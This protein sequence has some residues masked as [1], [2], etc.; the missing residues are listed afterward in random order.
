MNN[1]FTT[2]IDGA[3]Q[4]PTVVASIVNWNCH[5]DTAC[6]IDNLQKL[7]Y[8]NLKIIIVDNA[9]SDESVRILSTKYPSVTLLKADENNGYAAG[10]KLAV[11]LAISEQIDLVW[12][13]N[14][15]VEFQ[16]AAVL[17]S[18]VSAYME[19]GEGI[20][21]SVNITTKEHL[22]QEN[23]YAVGPKGLPSEEK[24]LHSQLPLETQI[25][26]SSP[27]PV[28]YAIGSSYM[29][30]TSV[31]KR[32]GFM[33]ERF[34]MY[35]EE[36]EYCYRLARQNVRT[37]LVPDSVVVH[38][39]KKTTKG[40]AI[41]TQIRH[42]YLRRNTLILKRKYEGWW[43][44]LREVLTRKTFKLVLKGLYKALLK[45][46]SNPMYS[47]DYLAYLAIRDSIINRIGKTIS[48][49]EHCDKA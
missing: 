4:F 21:G 2:H 31:I 30:P 7:L 29:I 41:L 48:P 12:L 14:P 35:A 32:F 27:I 38:E 16:N 13:L 3:G 26:T 5:E 25:Q 44:Y 10:H 22:V 42:Y 46:N 6:C 47:R 20:F 28:A 9:S 37:Y 19:L 15:D 23:W 24:I 11:E 34:F 40:S 17:D 18:L 8:P 33:D 49:D 1:A 43:P 36:R 45:R 39:G